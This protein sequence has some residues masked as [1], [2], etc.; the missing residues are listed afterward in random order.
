MLNSNLI[1]KSN[2]GHVH[3]AY[4]DKI[5]ARA[6][7]TVLAAPNG[8]NGAAE[9][10][11]LEEEDLPSNIITLLSYLDGVKSNVQT[12]IDR[13]SSVSVNLKS[14]TISDCSSSGVNN[15]DFSSS[16]DYISATMVILIGVSGSSDSKA[17][18]IKN[19]V[20]DSNN[21]LKAKSVS[22]TAGVSQN[23]TVNMAFVKIS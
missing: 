12:Q 8:N 5:S 4:Y 14:L 22:F 3:D 18:N 7:N 20:A 13:K 21:A 2:V 1:N 16:A 6:K 19:I 9:F 17:I 23:V 11:N 15:A 10:R